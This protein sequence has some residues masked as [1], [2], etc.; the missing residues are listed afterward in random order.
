MSL[1]GIV[2]VPVYL[3]YYLTLFPSV[4]GGDSGELLGNACIGGISHPPGYPTFS[5]LSKMAELFTVIPRFYLSDSANLLEYDPQ[6]TVAWKVNNLCAFFGACSAYFVALSVGIVLK[7]LIVSLQHK[8][9]SSQ[10][11][12]EGI[13]S[14]SQVMAAYLYALSPLTW[15]Y[16]GQTSEVFA[17]NNCLCSCIVY[18]TCRL[19]T[20]NGG[21]M[22]TNIYL[23]LGAVLS[24]LCFSNQHSSL[25]FLV[26]LIPYCFF[27]ALTRMFSGQGNSEGKFDGKFES[28]G[29]IMAV[30]MANIIISFFIGVSPYYYLYHINQHPVKGSWGNL[31]SLNGLM[32]HIFRME[33]GTFQL[34]V[35]RVGV[36]GVGERLMA[37]VKHVNNESFYMAFPLL[38]IAIYYQYAY[39]QFPD[40]FV[41]KQVVEHPTKQKKMKKTNTL[42][43]SSE[44]ITH[45]ESAPFIHRM[46]TSLFACLLNT[47]LFYTL[48]WHGVLSNLPL[49]SPMPYLVHARFWMQP[50]IILN[51]LVGCGYG[52]VCMLY[53]EHTATS[54]NIHTASLLNVVSV[55]SVL[56]YLRFP[57]MN[58]STSGWVMHN[59]GL[60]ILDSLPPNSLLM[61]HTD[62]DLNPVRYLKDCEKMRPDVVQLS[63]QMMPFAWFRDKQMSLYKDISF[64]DMSWEG[65]STDRKSMGNTRLVHEFLVANG[66]SQANVTTAF[67]TQGTGKDGRKKKRKKGTLPEGGI[68]LDMQSVQ[69]SDIQAGGI[70]HG[71]TLVPWG[72]L[73]R[74]FVTSSIREAEILHKTSYYQYLE[75]QRHLPVSPITPHFIQQYPDGTWEYAVINIYHDSQMQ[76]GLYLLTY[77]IE[78]MN[79]ASMESLPITL[80][81]LHLAASLL[82]KCKNSVDIWGTLSSSKVDLDKNVAVAWMKLQSLAKVAKQFTRQ[83]VDI[84]QDQKQ[85]ND[86]MFFNNDIIPSLLDEGKYDAMK[87]V[88]REVMEVFVKQY[89][90]DKDHEAFVAFLKQI[91]DVP[92]AGGDKGRRKE[93]TTKQTVAGEGEKKKLK[94]NRKSKK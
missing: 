35:T 94:R 7:D 2:L 27:T 3:V 34:G 23:C 22:I 20:H 89:P 37:Y 55:I 77:G 91:D 56:L 52:M 88:T 84:Q 85:R 31:D 25:L 68:Y 62:L 61:A 48:I 92:T 32:K 36:E 24:G 13:I 80:D 46:L 82:Y 81:R 29:V 19:F 71:L 45:S 76:L 50:S 65:I 49:S 69:D 8:F 14:A 90:D 16:G 6:P 66:I 11:R 53:N 73:Y 33:Y 60:A 59:Y 64:P 1:V 63:W 86:N 21:V 74:V 18:L 5:L 38:A 70:W 41:A 67:T 40:K 28:K 30:T 57:V 87:R 44:A 43:N 78:M 42:N 9:V 58:R 4:P 54:Q 72:P 12:I 10:S 79:G 47:W 83:L 93:D 15:E 39:V 51:I 17:L 75:L 26:I